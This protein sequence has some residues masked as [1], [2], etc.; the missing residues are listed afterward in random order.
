[1]AISSAGLEGVSGIVN[2]FPEFL[3]DYYCIKFYDSLVI[4]RV[5]GSVLNII[6]RWDMQVS[7]N[8]L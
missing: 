4:D 8:E 3:R 2:W 7:T 6:L 1:V 5:L